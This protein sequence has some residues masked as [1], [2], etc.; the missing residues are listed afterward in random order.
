MKKTFVLFDAKNMNFKKR[1]VKFSAPYITKY[2]ERDGNLVK[3]GEIILKEAKALLLQED[4]PVQHKTFLQNVLIKE[5]LPYFFCYRFEDNFKTYTERR[6]FYLKLMKK[7]S[8]LHEVL[9]LNQYRKRRIENILRYA[10]HFAT[11]KETRGFL[12]LVESKYDLDSPYVFQEE[13]YEH[14]RIVA[15]CIAKLA[16]SLSKDILFDVEQ[17]IAA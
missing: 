9:S 12:A 5:I 3:E 1:R 11:T 8:V 4:L 7:R 17:K 15:D 13:S 14:K 2:Y 6:T 10:K 16:V